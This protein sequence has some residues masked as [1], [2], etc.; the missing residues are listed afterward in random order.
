[1]KDQRGQPS[2]CPIASARSRGLDEDKYP[3][4]FQSK[5]DLAIDGSRTSVAKSH[6]VGVSEMVQ[7][8]N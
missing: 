8:K 1:M 4:G 7:L 6:R 5:L 3:D 2:R